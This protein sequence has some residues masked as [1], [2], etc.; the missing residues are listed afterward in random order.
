MARRIRREELQRYARQAR[1]SLGNE[2]VEAFHRLSEDLFSG[3]ERFEQLPDPP[4]RRVDAIRQLGRHPLPGEDPLNAVVRWCS[5]RCTSAAAAS[6]SLRGVKV[7]LKDMIA[8]ADLPMTFGSSVLTDYCSNEDAD[9]TRRLLDEGAEIVAITNMESFALSAGGEMT[10]RGPV[11]N[12]FDVTRTACGSSSGSAA[13]LFYEGV[14]LTFGTDQGGSVRIPASWCGVLGLKPTHGL[15]PYTGIISAD[16]RFDHAGPL[17]RDLEMLARGLD[18]VADPRAVDPVARE[19]RSHQPGEYVKALEDAPDSLDGIRIGVLSEG[20]AAAEDPAAPEGSEETAT[21]VHD[22][23]NRFAELGATVRCVSVPEHTSGSDIMFVAL[24]ETISATL[25]GAPSGH[26]LWTRSSAHLARGLGMAIEANGDELPA[27]FKLI[28]I[29]GTS[30][31]ERYF[32][33]YGARAH[34]MADQM[35]AAYD[36]ALAEVDVLLMP[37]TTH[38]AHP[39]RPEASV[40]ERVRRGTTMLANSGSFNLTGHPA[41]SI[42]A[43]E[44][45]GLPVGVQLVAPRFGERRLLGIT[46]VYEREH[47]W[48]PARKPLVHGGCTQL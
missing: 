3:V 41:L 37:T 28:A 47:G 22:A 29:L 26:A 13:A 1:F 2:E 11:L 8:V 43:A 10:A 38:Y 33:S 6:G 5:V 44:V 24:A 27:M 14:D 31:R 34:A 40:E 30:L 35:R 12:P 46:R 17:A 4:L 39:L 7:G 19:V 15:I 48:V 16:W 23:V 36:R 18:A 20:F 45:R 32:G 9:L 25:H 21:A 42:P